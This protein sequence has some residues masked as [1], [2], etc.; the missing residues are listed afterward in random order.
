M[1]KLLLLVALLYFAAGFLLQRKL[2]F[3]V[4]FAN[5]HLATQG[6]AGAGIERFESHWLETGAGKTEYWLALA[7]EASATSPSPLVVF[8]HGN[9]EL[10]DDQ[11]SLVLALQARGLSVA[12]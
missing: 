1:I 11:R 4:G 12:L 6:T 5:S 2:I 10:I 3:P 7:P 8:A 9:G